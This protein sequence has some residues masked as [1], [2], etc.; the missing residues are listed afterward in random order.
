[1][2]TLSI[3]SSNR[4]INSERKQEINNSKREFTFYLQNKLLLMKA[5]KL[6]NFFIFVENE[7][8]KNKN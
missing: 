3:F 7:P 2:L 5:E 6:Y 1:M 4:P 8:K